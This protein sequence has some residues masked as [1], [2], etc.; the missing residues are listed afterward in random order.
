M[1]TLLFDMSLIISIEQVMR[2]LHEW[3]IAEETYSG[4][5]MLALNIMT[6]MDGQGYLKPKNNAGQGWLL[7]ELVK[8]ITAVNSLTGKPKLF[9]V[10]AYIE[11]ES[12]VQCPELNSSHLGSLNS[13]VFIGLA[14][15]NTHIAPTD[16]NEG[17]YFIQSLSEC[18]RAHHKSMAL[19]EM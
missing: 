7:P 9:F 16:P 15:I 11:G 4:I 19:E 17:T 8:T 2:K 18:L 10:N 12:V 6:H 5:S 13:D 14:T 1:Y 3:L